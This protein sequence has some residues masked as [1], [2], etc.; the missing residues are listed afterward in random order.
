MKNTAKQ[1]AKTLY[2]LTKEDETSRVDLILGNFVK[3]LQRNGQLKMKNAIIEK[4]E[5]IHNA[6]NGVIAGEMIFSHEPD[7]ELVEKVREFV[8]NKYGAKSVTLDKKID[9]RIKGGVIIKIG[10]QIFDGSVLMQLDRLRSSL[11]K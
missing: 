3:I 9:E 8:R 4:F 2:E 1:Y 5:N 11:E 10:D 7:A 6:E